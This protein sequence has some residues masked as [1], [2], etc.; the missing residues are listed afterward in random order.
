MGTIETVVS[1]L[2][3]G[4]FDGFHSRFFFSFFFSGLTLE[5]LNCRHVGDL[6]IVGVLLQFESC[7]SHG[8]G[9]FNCGFHEFLYQMIL[10]R[11]GESER[12]ELLSP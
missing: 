10:L 7:S 2:H 5:S 9:V 6:R 11:S 1:C 8:I 4:C 12:R 3:R